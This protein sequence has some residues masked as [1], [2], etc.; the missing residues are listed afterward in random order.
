MVSY[1]IGFLLLI[2]CPKSAHDGI[3]QPWYA[4]YTS[5]LG[6]FENI[7][8]Y[9]NSLKLFGPGLGYYPEPSKSVLIINADHI[10]LCNIF[11]V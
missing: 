7:G 8:L 10:N 5:A 4:E 11:K 1:G 6:T 9:F 2:K 3:T